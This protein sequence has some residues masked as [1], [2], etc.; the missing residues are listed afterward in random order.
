ML[1][2]MTENLTATGILESAIYS[3]LGFTTV[4]L[5]VDLNEGS[6]KQGNAR[7][8]YV[9]SNF[10]VAKPLKILT[11]HNKGIIKCEQ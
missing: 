3:A 7:R 2:Q 5:N 9:G 11:L 4:M 10:V 8:A 6:S 1:E